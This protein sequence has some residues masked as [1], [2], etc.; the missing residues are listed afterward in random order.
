MRSGR[1]SVYLTSTV[2]AAV[3]Y[4]LLVGNFLRRVMCV[5]GKGMACHKTCLTMFVTALGVVF[6]RGQVPVPLATLRIAYSNRPGRGIFP[7]F[8]SFSPSSLPHPTP[9]THPH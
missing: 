4:G 7:I 2:G 8:P 1:R 6:V 9:R 5:G 3:G